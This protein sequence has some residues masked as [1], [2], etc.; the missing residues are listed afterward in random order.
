MSGG[1]KQAAC[2][3]KGQITTSGVVARLPG[4]NGTFGCSAEFCGVAWCTRERLNTVYGP[5]G[6][7]GEVPEAW[8]VCV[9]VLPL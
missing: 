3:R 4:S 5:G 1:G 7:K 6:D 9:Q 2:S 8:Q